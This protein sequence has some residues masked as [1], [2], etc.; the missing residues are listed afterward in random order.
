LIRS[1]FS[2]YNDRLDVCAP[3]ENILTTG[4]PSYY[5]YSNYYMAAGTSYSAPYVSGVAALACCIDANLS[6][7]EF[8]TL[9][10]DTSI[11]L[12]NVAMIRYMDTE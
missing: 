3:G 4:N 2:N 9:L 7:I 8:A 5:P 1:D 6:N 10:R 12:G 11:D